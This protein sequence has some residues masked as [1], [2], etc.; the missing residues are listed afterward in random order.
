MPFSRVQP[1]KKQADYVVGLFLP[2][3]SKVILSEGTTKAGIQ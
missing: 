2:L 3:S 1:E